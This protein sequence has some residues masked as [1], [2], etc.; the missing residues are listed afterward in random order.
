MK[1]HLLFADRDSG[2]RAS[3]TYRIGYEV[4]GPQLPP[5]SNDLV[6]DLDLLP[7]FQAMGAG[8]PFLAEISR[9]VLL[10]S[11][12]GV[13]AI[14]YRQAVLADCLA[15]PEMIRD[16]YALAEESI[17][18]QSKFYRSVFD[19]P[20]S[21]LSRSISVLEFCVSQLR[22]LRALAE[23]HLQAVSSEGLRTLFSMLVRELDDQYFDEIGRHLQRLRLRGG[24]PMSA[25]LGRGLKGRDYRLLRPESGRRS[26]RQLVGLD[27]PG[28][29][30]FVL[31]DRDEA[32][33]RALAE[34]ES[35][36]IDRAADALARSGD[37]I[38][39]FLTM[40]AIET[41]F[42]LACLNLHDR[43]STLG[44]PSCMP[45]LH[46]SSELKLNLHD[47]IDVSLALQSE[48]AVVGN[49]ALADGKELVVVTGANSGGK[50]TFLRSL[51][52][53]QLMAQSGAF[54]SAA[55]FSSSVCLGIFTHFGRE[56][57]PTMTMGKLDEELARMSA[58]VQVVS[59]RSL[60]LFNESFAATNEREGS[61]IGRQVITALLEGGMRVGLVT[62]LYTL[63]KTLRDARRASA[64]FLRAERGADG[65]RSFKLV[66]GEPLPTS[67]GA[68]LYRR[69]GGW[70]RTHSGP[71]LDGEAGAPAGRGSAGMG[72]SGDFRP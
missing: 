30:S 35:R 3:W 51:G 37:H 18:G 56:E 19:S 41:G 5:L 43:L 10:A 1:A 8:D 57:D 65:R 23:G 6:H 24:V 48:R 9:R 31:S 49:G 45:V 33:A 60:V 29:H 26:L 21:T 72:P 34:L 22:K 68:D 16:V 2:L 62:H 71:E 46:P 55:S 40:L 12:E 4:S 36:G 67:F 70:P 13:A 44:A 59:A 15:R 11:L 14:R 66:E 38:T 54:V 7:L 58:I 53:A 52:I 20:A 42:Y 39:S 32:G 28:S 17:R 27:R 64:L 63:A 25:S 61:E 47:L 69:M 50:S